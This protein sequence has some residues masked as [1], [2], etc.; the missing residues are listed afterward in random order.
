MSVLYVITA[1][2]CQ[3]LIASSFVPP[4]STRIG[5][6]FPQFGL[7]NSA[8]PD[9]RQLLAAFLMAVRDINADPHLLP[10]TT[11]LVALKDSRLN[12]GKTFF[13]SLELVSTS[14]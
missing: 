6:L 1:F 9:G 12:V 7:D 10:N 5:G 11:M 13:D 4:T 2:L 8:Q 3:F 14:F